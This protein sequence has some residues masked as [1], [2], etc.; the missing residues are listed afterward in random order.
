MIES[1]VLKKLVKEY[2]IRHGMV[3]RYPFLDTIAKK[4]NIEIKDLMKILGIVKIK[5]YINPKQLL[6]KNKFTIKI[7]S[8]EELIEIVSEIN[9]KYGIDTL[10]NQTKKINENYYIFSNQ[11]LEHV[12][13]NNA[14][15]YKI[16]LKKEIVKQVRYNDYI[17]KL[18]I[19]KLRNIEGVNDSI[20][21]EALSINSKNFKNLINGKVNKTRIVIYSVIRKSFLLNMDL[22]YYETNRFFSKRELISKSQRFNLTLEEMLKNIGTSVKRYKYDLIALD[23]NKKGIYIGKDHR[24][25]AKFIEINHEEIRRICNRNAKIYANK[26]KMRHLTAEFESI[27]FEYILQNGGIIEKNFSFD[28]NLLFSIISSRCKYRIL[29]ECKNNIRERINLKKYG[30]QLYLNSD[31]KYDSIPYIECNKKLEGYIKRN[32]VKTYGLILI[33]LNLIENMALK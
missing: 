24:M 30:A 29:T 15:K 11:I 17:T 7:Y 31:I 2:E 32:I 28:N 10:R 12:V 8:D 33:L 26:Y 23:K 16:E 20:I 6:N 13:H 25:S 1:K 4:E 3:V 5:E 19:Q 21:K 22:K 18:E 27:A 14:L 9:G